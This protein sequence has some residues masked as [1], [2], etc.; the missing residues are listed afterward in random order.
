M[1]K[2]SVSVPLVQAVEN[3]WHAI[4]EINPDVPDVVITMGAGIT[5]RGLKLGHFAAST[6]TTG[7]DGQPIHELFV[8][9]EG[10]ARG[11]QAVMG[12]LLHEATHAMAENLGVKDTSRGGRYHN[13]KFQDLATKL[14]IEV[15]HS[16][17]LG[18][19]TTTMPDST[20]KV[21]ETAIMD[22]DASITAH[23]F[24]WELFAPVAGGNGTTGTSGTVKAP[25][26][27]G[28]KSSNN[29]LS[30]TCGCAEPRKIRVSLSTAELG[31]I[32]CGVCGEA[33]T[34]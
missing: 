26:A 18:W 14:G 8:G 9:A 19:S 4:Q 22:L 13:R 21:Y 7:E 25:L 24:G 2:Q 12:T 17:E 16:T 10:L 15:E 34:E 1:S 6:W 28:R 33:F 32:T 3:A 27:K 11:A 31:D 23:R 29:G 20:A 30:L 5:A